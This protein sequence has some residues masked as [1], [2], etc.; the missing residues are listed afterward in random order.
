MDQPLV[1]GAETNTTGLKFWNFFFFLNLRRKGTQ[2]NVNKKIGNGVSAHFTAFP[3]RQ[4]GRDEGHGD[5]I[6]PSAH[7]HL[8]QKALPH[9]WILV[10]E[11]AQLPGHSRRSKPCVRDGLI[12]THVPRT[13]EMGEGPPEPRRRP[14]TLGHPCSSQLRRGLP[15]ATAA[16]PAQG[17]VLENRA[18]TVYAP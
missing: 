17:W 3:L 7:P 12:E 9:V 14:P 18:H 1:R 2:G 5:P 6:L 4:P 10:P 13:E 8:F 15:V 11:D 16:A